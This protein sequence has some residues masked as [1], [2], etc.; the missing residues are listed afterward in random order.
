M[1]TWLIKV[2]L[3][4]IAM[5]ICILCRTAPSAFLQVVVP[6]I[7]AVGVA[8][9]VESMRF[10]HKR[11]PLWPALLPMN[12][13]YGVTLQLHNN[14]SN[15][16][17]LTKYIDCYKIVAYSIIQLAEKNSSEQSQSQRQT[18]SDRRTTHRFRLQFNAY[19]KSFSIVMD[20]ARLNRTMQCN[21]CPAKVIL[22]RRR[23]QN[24][25]LHVITHYIKG[26]VHGEDTFGHW[27]YSKSGLHGVFHTAEESYYIEPFIKYFKTR[28]RLHKKL[29]VV[30]RASDINLAAKTH[31]ISTIKQQSLWK[32]EQPLLL[33]GIDY[34]NNTKINSH[35]F[36]KM[37]NDYT[38]LKHAR[39][40]RNVI[41]VKRTCTLH[42]VADYSFY[43]NIG[44]EQVI[45][46]INEIVHYV[47]EADA[48]FRHVDF[49]GDGQSDNIGFSLG[50]ITI[51]QDTD[52]GGLII[53]RNNQ[54][55]SEVLK[56]FSYNNFSDYCLGILFT[57]T[58]FDT[59]TLGLSWVA[60]S[61]IY[62]SPGGICQ[63]SMWSNQ[64]WHSFNTIMLSTNNHGETVPRKIA[65]MT[66]THEIGHAFGSAHDEVSDNKCAP[67]GKYGHY[68]M[69][70]DSTYTSKPN[71]MLFSQCSIE[72]IA[73]VVDTK[74]DCFKVDHT[75]VCG[76]WL[77]EPGEEC[78]C[79]SSAAYCKV[80]DEC[81]TAP[82]ANQ[83]GCL[84][85]R[86][87]GKLCSP[88]T[89]ACCS[90]ECGVE[91]KHKVCRPATD[92]AERS[93]CNGVN[94][95]CPPPEILP[96]GTI[97]MDGMRVCSAGQC[98]TSICQY[99]EHDECQCTSGADTHCQ[100]CCQERNKTDS[101]CIPANRL[102]IVDD[103][104]YLK[105]GQSCR[106]YAGYCDSKHRCV[107]VNAEAALLR[108]RDV[109]RDTT[110]QSFT[111]WLQN[112]WFFVAI[113]LAVV[114]ISVAMLRTAL[115][116]NSPD[117]MSA[118]AYKS[119]TFSMMWQQMQ[120]EYDKLSE[121]RNVLEECYMQKANELSEGRHIGLL[122]GVTRITS[123]FPT[124]S[125]T[126]ITKAVM[127][128][129]NEEH[130]VS[131]LLALGYPIREQ[132]TQ[133]GLRSSTHSY[134]DCNDTIEL[135]NSQW[136]NVCVWLYVQH[137]SM[138]DIITVNVSD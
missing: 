11:L 129:V 62:G 87:E 33:S 38:H 50:K 114:F 137:A 35:T 120:E 77:V 31:G 69:H 136:Y 27:T 95:D 91:K 133:M 36:Y 103:R 79:G 29:I 71:N 85:A 110:L 73:P 75:A 1:D 39:I 10:S 88:R 70:A 106:N 93:T 64:R 54:I 112:Y 59:G 63:K 76:N 61:S 82:T 89:S 125:R 96:N 46:T 41:N 132:N 5:N 84:I 17:P 22:I 66:L 19:Q 32:N 119:S 100:L 14:V 56:T 135:A 116:K 109:F 127:H 57:H 2:I 40:K 113:V 12:A 13:N 23:E 51:L 58:N 6:V 78:D 118:K 25:Y 9:P 131:Q 45:D 16:I 24:E 18:Q 94:I 37:T 128:S 8:V 102:G 67:G 34:D 20:V 48:A 101:P 130:V 122:V 4:R 74:S 43:K 21:I 44:N 28:M 49:N 98:K 80:V 126:I 99:H 42:A 92:C 86:G 90:F 117:A 60:S 123:L 83:P 81:C 104:I 121:Q 47:H 65:S 115:K 52:S 97:C 53:S 124:V 30:Y 15:C 111:K 55:A 68:L 108:L 138:C 107:M 3:I 26:H 134:T 72:F 7:V 105:H